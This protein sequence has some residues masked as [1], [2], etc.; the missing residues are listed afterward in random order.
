MKAHVVDMTL[1]W[2]YVYYYTY[3]IC[4]KLIYNIQVTIK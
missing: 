2:I 4:I 1:D 3:S